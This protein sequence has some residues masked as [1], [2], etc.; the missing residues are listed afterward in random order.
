MGRPVLSLLLHW[1]PTLVKSGCK[2]V[3]FTKE[4]EK[5]QLLDLLFWFVLCRMIQRLKA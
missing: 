1:D 4:E 5:Q 3:P 2:A